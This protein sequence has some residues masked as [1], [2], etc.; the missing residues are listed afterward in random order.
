MEWYACLP[1]WLKIEYSLLE[2]RTVVLAAKEHGADA[3]QTEK[4]QEITYDRV[5]APGRKRCPA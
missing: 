3:S 5:V 2:I 1:Y 4:S